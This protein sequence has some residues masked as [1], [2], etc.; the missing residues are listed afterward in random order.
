L[1]RLNVIPDLS[2]GK[3]LRLRIF[4]PDVRWNRIKNK[5]QL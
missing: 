1:R 3:R 2:T 4:E 5:V